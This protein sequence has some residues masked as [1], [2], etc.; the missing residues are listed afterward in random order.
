MV[1][2]I[3][4]MQTLRLPLKS[5]SENISIFIHHKIWAN[6]RFFINKR[7]AVSPVFLITDSN[8]ETIYGKEINQEL[9]RLTNYSGMFSFPAGE[10]SK[11]RAVKNKLEDTL[12]RNKA[13]RDAIVLAMGGGVTGDL[14]GFIAANL[15]R[16]V[17]LIHMPTSLIAQVDSSIGGKVGI[18][19]PLGK[20]LLGN[21][22]Q[23]RAVFINVSFLQTLPDDELR[24]GIAEVIKYAVILD[25]KLWDVVESER[26]NILEKNIHILEKVVT[27]CVRSKIQVVSRD[28]KEKHYRSILNF[29]HTVGHAI[30]KLSSYQLKHGVAIA[31]GMVVAAKISARLLGYPEKNV[32]RLIHCLNS[33]ELLNLDI[34]Q[35]DPNEVWDVILLDKKSRQ[36]KPRFTLL[37]SNCK[38]QLF[39]EVLKEELKSAL[40]DC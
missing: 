23:P 29:G 19:H 15:H 40:K 36:A 8:I 11:S 39:Q 35:Y 5:K 38:P 37:D 24:N 16:G 26:D 17:S 18:N 31:T 2:G 32:E 13:G 21:F 20:N 10:K 22:Y 34:H 12:L 3:N 28:E 9:L 27:R 1:N 4:S 25:E 7:F 30:E 6:L 14:V 33:Y